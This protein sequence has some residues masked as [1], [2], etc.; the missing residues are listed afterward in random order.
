ME[1]DL[2]CHSGVVKWV[3]G[4]RSRER[5]LGRGRDRWF[6]ETEKRLLANGGGLAPEAPAGRSLR[7]PGTT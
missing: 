4:N 7:M 1:F 6:L 3:V 2:I 5:R